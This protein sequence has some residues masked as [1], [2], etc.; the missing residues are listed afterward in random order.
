MAKLCC[1]EGC[2][3]AALY[4]PVLRVPPQGGTMRQA[5]ELVLGLELCRR[6][7]GDV[8][9]G[10]VLLPESRQRIRVALMERGWAMPDFERAEIERGSIGDRRWLSFQHV[11]AS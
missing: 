8:E 6:H 3:R 9:A 2:T 5:L 4:Y 10:D 7:L 11:R 1:R